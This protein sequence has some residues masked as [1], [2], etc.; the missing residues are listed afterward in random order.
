[1]R[2]RLP[3][4]PRRLDQETEPVAVR[5]PMRDVLVADAATEAGRGDRDRDRECRQRGHPHMS[6]RPSPPRGDSAPSPVLPRCDR[7]T[8]PS[9]D[10]DPERER[11]RDAELSEVPW[12][13]WGPYVAARAWG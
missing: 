2:L 9:N 11:M 3:F 6:A 7:M 13:A 4:G 12:R 8:E 10:L 5:R 1:A